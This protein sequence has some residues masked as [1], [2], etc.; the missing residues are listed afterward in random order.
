MMKG[1]NHGT[2]EDQWDKKE[3]RR[4]MRRIEDLQQKRSKQENLWIEEINWESRKFISKRKNG[5]HQNENTNKEDR[6]P[7]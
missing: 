3:M 5:A 2:N 1:K 7:D 6:S 4:K